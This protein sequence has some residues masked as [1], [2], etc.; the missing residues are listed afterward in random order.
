MSTDPK[1]GIVYATM[2]T[3]SDGVLS[4]GAQ[5]SGVLIA[6]DEI[7]TAAHCVTGVGKTIR[8]FGTVCA[9]Y[10]GAPS[11][12][13]SIAVDGVHV[14][15]ASHN[16]TSLT[17][18]LASTDYALL[19]LSQAISGGTVFSLASA[20][21]GG[22]F[23]VDGY[24]AAAAGH[25]AELQE[26]LSP[27]S[28]SGELKGTAIAGTADSRGGSGGPVWSDTSGMPTV[29]GIASGAASDGSGVFKALTSQD[30]A[31]ID[32]WVQADHAS[33]QPA[34]TSTT[35][36][37]PVAPAPDPLDAL[38]SRL[39]A[40][41]DAHGGARAQ[42]LSDVASAL[43]SARQEGFV[44]SDLPDA[45]D[46]AASLLKSGSQ[47]PGKSVAFMAG[48]M[49][50]EAG[51]SSATGRL[52]R[53]INLNFGLSLYSRSARQAVIQGYA[54][55]SSL[56]SYTATARPVSAPTAQNFSIGDLAATL[57]RSGSAANTSVMPSLRAEDHAATMPVLTAR[58][59]EGLGVNG[60]A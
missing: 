26:T 46:R 15:D 56:S 1:S 58:H 29:V 22:T 44:Y 19:H 55:D 31:Q 27:G 17:D 50:A 33:G 42:L 25:L 18:A 43:S 8:N 28:V 11:S 49:G 10:D 52:L 51:A 9:G 13:G 12:E 60:M 4:D 21:Q 24:P 6:P 23:E 32:A 35:I 38:A 57:N 39:Q 5:F 30:I 36:A 45:V 7:L 16:D 34:L 37:A 14:L 47:T 20:L 59:T 53:Y 40:D 2:Y 41:A 3:S 54:E 48:L